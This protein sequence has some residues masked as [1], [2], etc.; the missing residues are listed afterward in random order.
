MTSQ[1]QK[2]GLMGGILSTFRPVNFHFPPHSHKER[3]R[4]ARV[5]GFV[6]KRE[7]VG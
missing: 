5:L 1:K 7:Q 4:E 2:L 3:D 6:K